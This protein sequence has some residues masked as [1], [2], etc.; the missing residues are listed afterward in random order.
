MEGDE[1]A[2]LENLRQLPTSREDVKKLHGVLEAAPSTEV[3]S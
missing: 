2:V 3:T 1:S